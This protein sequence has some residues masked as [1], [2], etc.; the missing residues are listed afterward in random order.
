VRRLIILGIVMAAIAAGIWFVVQAANRPPDPYFG[1]TVAGFEEQA[2]SIAAPGVVTGGD[3]HCALL[4]ATAEQRSR[5]LMGRR[6]LGGYDGMVFRFDEPATTPFTMSRTLIPLS[7]A[8]FDASG[9]LV[10]QAEM[11]PCPEAIDCPSYQSDRPYLY[12]LE[13]AQGGLDDLGVG[14]GALLVLGN[15]ACS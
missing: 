1:P 8:W 4:A 12:A 9:A 6:D 3:D 11:T 2:F 7:I 14:A 10:D 5:G 13:V 15:G